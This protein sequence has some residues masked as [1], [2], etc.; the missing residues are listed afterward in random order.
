MAYGR[1]SS[2]AASESL[3]D[4][5]GHGWGGVDEGQAM[6]ARGARPRTQ[7]HATTRNHPPIRSLARSGMNRKPRSVSLCPSAPESALSTAHVPRP[8][9]HVPRLTSHGSPPT[10]G[11]P[12]PQSM[13]TQNIYYRDSTFPSVRTLGLLPASH[14]ATLLSVSTRPPTPNRACS[15]SSVYYMQHS[16]CRDDHRS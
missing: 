3:I 7:P 16:M 15:S 8:T 13:T 9:A 4:A 1:L 11:I 14:I 12:L 5:L 2:A 6:N 10:P